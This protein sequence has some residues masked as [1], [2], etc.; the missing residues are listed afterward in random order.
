MFCG[1]SWRH[2]SSIS[3]NRI[4]VMAIFELMIGLTDMATD[5]DP[6]FSEAR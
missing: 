1:P 5:E 2:S 4:V 3:P 6:K